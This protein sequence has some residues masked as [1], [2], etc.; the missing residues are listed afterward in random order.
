VVGV[1]P[2][3]RRQAAGLLVWRRTCMPRTTPLML[4]TTSQMPD[5]I[6]N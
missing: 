4:M 6:V 5:A 2:G 1:S 3:R